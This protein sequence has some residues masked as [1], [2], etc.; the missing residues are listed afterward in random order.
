MNFLFPAFLFA[1]AAIAIPI[2]LHFRRQPPQKAVPFSSLMFL[3]QSPV[4][5][6]TRRKLE[7]WLLLALRCL[8]LLL[9]ALMFSRPFLRGQKQSASSG[10]TRWC[11]LVDTSASMRRPEAW[12]AAAKQFNE[13]V[14]DFAED[15][16]A[17]LI[18]FDRA[19]RVVVSADAWRSTPPG[20]RVGLLKSA[21]AELKPTWAGTDLGRA[22]LFAAE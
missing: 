16:S 5:P 14:A 6:R 10:G 19:P 22:L 4:P 3:E 12:E 17:E 1:A 8:A 15:D 21:W 7:D 9:L 13:A 18:A 2:L 20:A 11:L